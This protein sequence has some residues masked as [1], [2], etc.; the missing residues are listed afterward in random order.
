MTQFSS[1][2]N[3]DPLLQSVIWIS[4][5]IRAANYTHTTSFPLK[6]ALKCVVYMCICES[7]PSSPHEHD[8][9]PIS[10]IVYIFLNILSENNFP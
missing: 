3:H 2:F 7:P 6:I 10:F 9:H 5:E 4:D 8:Q 1:F